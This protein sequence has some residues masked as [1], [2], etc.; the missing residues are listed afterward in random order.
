MYF[1]TDK[2]VQFKDFRYADKIITVNTTMEKKINAT[3]FKKAKYIPNAIN[4][5]E[6]KYS[7][8]TIKNNNKFV[9]GA[10]GRLVKKKGFDLLI[11]TCSEMKNVELLIAGQGEEF[12]NLNNISKNANNI[13][14]LGWIESKD[15]FFSNIDIFCSSSIEEPFGIVIIEAM[16]RGVAIVS[17]KCNGPVDIIKNNKDGLLIEINNKVELMSAIT[18]LKDNINLRDKLGSN[19]KN[20]YKNKFTFKQYSKNIN[21][22]IKNL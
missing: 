18:K 4:T 15:K 10:M 21:T 6:K 16:A 3:Y 5:K 14:L 11:N 9:V 7:T 2:L 12:N 8:N 20:K 17:T 19:A 13:K 22:L 1:H